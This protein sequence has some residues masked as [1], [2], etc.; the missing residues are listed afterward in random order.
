V[1]TV[2]KYPLAIVGEQ[3]V[4]MPQGARI[5]CVQLQRGDLCLWALVNTA[6]VETDRTI[7]IIGTGN[8]A[9]HRPRTYLGTVQT[10]GGMLVWHVFELEDAR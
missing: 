1:I 7:E 9:H 3:V 4:P 8:P 10:A 5:L 6:N 2:Y